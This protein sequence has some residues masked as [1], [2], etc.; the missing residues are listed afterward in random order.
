MLRNLVLFDEIC[1]NAAVIAD[2]LLAQ[3]EKLKVNKAENGKW[4]TLQRVV[5]T[6]WSRNE[7]EALVKR[8]DNLKEAIK[9]RV[10]LVIL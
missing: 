6:L 10:L 7:I 8:L 2:E 3:L 5:K 1:E 4:K 9:T